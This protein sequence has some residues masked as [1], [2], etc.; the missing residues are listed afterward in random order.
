LV[1]P[2]C[3]RRRGCCARGCIVEQ[4]VFCHHR[5]SS[6]RF[7]LV[8]VGGDW[9]PKSP[10]LRF[11]FLFFFFPGENAKRDVLFE[12]GTSKGCRCSWVQHT[13][14][15]KQREKSPLLSLSAVELMIPEANLSTSHPISR[16]KQMLNY[17]GFPRGRKCCFPNTSDASL[18]VVNHS[19]LRR[20]KALSR[21]KISLLFIL[22]IIHCDGLGPRRSWDS[23]FLSC[24]GLEIT[25]PRS[26]GW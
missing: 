12:T 10:M 22:F 13:G 9:Q 26:W 1:L 24:W 23:F 25:Q 19:E 21:C 20:W 14:V 15:M 5:G 7:T 11:C 8:M 17:W 18:F 16:W 3:S 6:L 2:P 4:R